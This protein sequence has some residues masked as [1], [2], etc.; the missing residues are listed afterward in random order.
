MYAENEAAFIERFALWDGPALLMLLTASSAMAFMLIKLTR[1]VCCRSNYEPISDGFGRLLSI[2][3]RWLLF[4]YYFSFLKFQCFFIIYTQ[5]RTP[6][7]QSGSAIYQFC[8]F[9][10]VEYDFWFN[11][12][13]P[14]VC[15]TGILQKT[16][17][18]DINVDHMVN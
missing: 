17:A 5:L 9:L 10:F 18:Q 12:D 4:Q 14:R 13:S 2:S 6:R 1:K 8:V 16:Q 3:F 7:T 15:G 11:A